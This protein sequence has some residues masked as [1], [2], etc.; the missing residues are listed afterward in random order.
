MSKYQR[1]KIYKI[2]DNTNG[3]IYIGS[4]CEPML[5]RRLAKHKME[6][7]YYIAKRPGQCFLTCFKILENKNYNIVLVENYPCQTKDELHARERYY[8]E[9]S[10]CVNKYIPGRSKREYRETHKKK[11]RFL[12]KHIMRHIKKNYIKKI[13]CP[14]GSVYQKCSSMK[15]KRTFNHQNYIFQIKQLLK[16]GNEKIRRVNELI[17]EVKNIKPLNI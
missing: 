16:N 11:K 9:S 7:K 10:T 15:H 13:N 8:I 2:V 14:C 3:N 1:G 6:Y 12:I 4:T 5:S 17:N